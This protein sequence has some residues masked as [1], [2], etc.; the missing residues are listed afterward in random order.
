[1]SDLKRSILSAWQPSDRLTRLTAFFFFLSSLCSC[2]CY[3][4][5]CILMPWINQILIDCFSE[6]RPYIIVQDRWYY[7]GVWEGRDEAS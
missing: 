6:P 1:M 2:A 5:S 7:S 4:G 3:A